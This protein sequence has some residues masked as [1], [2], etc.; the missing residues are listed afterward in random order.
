M[1][2]RGRRAGTDRGAAAGV[3]VA[4][5]H[6]LYPDPWPKRRHNKRRVISDEMVAELARVL[7]PGG[8]MR[9][10]TDIDDYAGWTLRRFLGSPEFA[11]D[12]RTAGGLGG[13]RGR[14]GR[15]LRGEGAGGGARVGVF[16][17]PTEVGW[18]RQVPSRK[19]I[20][21]RRRGPSTVTV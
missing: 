12:A 5:L 9:F 16:D 19:P 6:L 4:R 18:L 10:A 15:A 11:W 8:E 21:R 20:R 14:A 7:K 17:V 2:V 13:C 3:F 1:R